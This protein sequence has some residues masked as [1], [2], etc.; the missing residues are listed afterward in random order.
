MK[1]YEKLAQDIRNLIHSGALASGERVPSIR[2]ASKTYRVSPSTVYQAYFLLENQGLIRSQPRSG[3]YVCNTLKRQP[4]LT[5]Q[6]LSPTQVDVSELVFSVLGSLSNPSIIPLGSAFPCPSFFPMTRLSQS[7]AKASR[8]MDIHSLV[9]YLPEGSV[10]LRRQ[11]L[12]RYAIADVHL[13]HDELVIT[14]G[15]LEALNL[16]L[17]AVTEPGDLVAVEAPAFYASL[18][19]LE[20]LKLKA[21]AIPVDPVNGIDLPTMTEAL[22]K[23][24]IKAGWFMSNFQNPTSASMSDPKKQALVALFT[25]HKVPLIE[26]DVYQELYFGNI[27][28]KS[29]KSFDTD[30]YV[31]HCSS[32][33]KCLAPGYRIGWCAAGKYSTK[34]HRLKLMTTL[35]SS[36]PAQLGIANY[37]QYGGY[38]RHLRKL[39]DTLELQHGYMT[40]AID[41][42]FPKNTR[43]LSA[44][45]GYFLW[46]ELPEHIDSLQLF[47]AA[48]NKNISIAPGPIFSATQGFKNCIRLNYG[49]STWTSKLENAIKTLGTLIN[50]H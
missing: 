34:I 27:P 10:A 21:I 50:E 48:L 17:Q 43:L 41:R 47:R 36:T 13:G 44:A 33:S 20:R 23:H 31:L 12:Q 9:S 11:L 38:D 30:G 24:P 25:K 26:D 19:A 4:A 45:G 29:L 37:L 6:V 3:Y 22:K 16:S 8:E 28:P 35:S 14:N 5:R 32:F 1:R 7:L 18:Q 42:Y 15:A 39:R 2:H 46:I 40:A 49:C